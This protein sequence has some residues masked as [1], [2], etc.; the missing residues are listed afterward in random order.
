MVP[1]TVEG[2]TTRS[3]LPQ[4]CTETI[5]LFMS[6]LPELWSKQLSP[7]LDD[8]GRFQT[9]KKKVAWREIFSRAALT[10]M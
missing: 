4:S 3:F 2:L 10:L 1:E 7:I 9:F 8:S 6:K 5:P